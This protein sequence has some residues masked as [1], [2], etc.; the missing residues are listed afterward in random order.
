MLVS[1]RKTKKTNLRVFKGLAGDD[2]YDDRP[3]I[4]TQLCCNLTVPSAS[5]V[6]TVYPGT[7]KLL[8]ESFHSHICRH[9]CCNR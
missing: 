2:M 4:Q 7:H 8:P 3:V 5:L 6:A 1:Q 9:L